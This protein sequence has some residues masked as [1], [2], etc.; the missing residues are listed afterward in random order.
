MIQ[1]QLIYFLIILLL[2]ACSAHKP[3][4]V[5]DRNYQKKNTASKSQSRQ[6]RR[7]LQSKT[8]MYTVRKG[9]TLYS[10]AFRYG[11]AFQKLAQWNHISKP[12]VIYPGQKLSFKAP[13]KK[14]KA[15]T[16][17]NP[18]I[19]LSK[20]S[21]QSVK[22]PVTSTK[23]PV[24]SSAKQAAN[25]SAQSKTATPTRWQWPV[26]G[27]LISSFN[28]SDP[29]RKGIDI[30]GNEGERIRAAAAGKVVYSGNGLRGYGELIIVKHANGYLTAYAHNRKRLVAEGNQVKAGQ[31]IAELGSTEAVRPM[32]HFEIRINGKPVDPLKYLP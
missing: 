11:L 9:D 8:G 32:L 3:A 31:S 15:I 5:E 27:R 17:S 18:G 4:W 13:N 6:K 24:K 19:R 23:T 29:G 20:S 30:A 10:I 22:A 16:Q 12:F 2:S 1:K 26:K 28:A 7:I 14:Q 21:A 25:A